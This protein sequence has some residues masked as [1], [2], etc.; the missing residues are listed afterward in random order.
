MRIYIHHG[1][2]ATPE[3]FRRLISLIPSDRW[4]VPTGVDRFSPREVIAHMADWEAILR[5]ERMAAAVA[6]PGCTITPYDESLRA[7]EQGYSIS[8]VELQLARFA[9]ER[10][11]TVLFLDRLTEEQLSAKMNHPERGEMTVAEHAAGMLGHDVYH[12]DQLVQVL[13]SQDIQVLISQDIRMG[14]P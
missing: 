12:I 8:D 10:A 2:Q 13:I 6:D 9:A 7:I 1:L 5:E 3:I 14:L 11:R 4:N